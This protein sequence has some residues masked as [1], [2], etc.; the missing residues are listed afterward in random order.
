MPRSDERQRVKGH[1]TP[2][3]FDSEASRPVIINDSLDQVDVV[4]PDAH[5]KDWHLTWDSTWPVP[6][7]HSLV[8]ALA[9]RVKRGPTA[10]WRA[11]NPEGARAARTGA[12]DCRQDRPGDTTTLESLAMR[13]YLS[14]EHLDRKFFWFAIVFQNVVA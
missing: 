9:R 10:R 2:G 14:G 8:F 13:I 5:G 3:V 6:R 7:L 11:I 12:T 4:L 1:N